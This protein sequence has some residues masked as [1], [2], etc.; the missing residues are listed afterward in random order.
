MWSATYMTS[1]HPDGN[2]LKKNYSNNKYPDDDGRVVADM[3][4]VV[5]VGMLDLIA[6]EGLRQRLGG[7]RPNCSANFGATHPGDSQSQYSQNQYG[8]SEPI[9]LTEGELKALMKASLKAALLLAGVFIGA[10]G[11]FILFCIYVWFR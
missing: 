9:E 4:Q 5:K 1:K 7:R 6:P 10:A 2:H 8:N 11:L 3:S